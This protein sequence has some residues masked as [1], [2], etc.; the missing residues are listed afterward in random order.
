M[1]GPN[2]LLLPD[3]GPQFRRILRTAAT[4]PFVV[5]VTAGVP[6]N[7]QAALGFIGAILGPLVGG[8]VERLK[9]R[10]ASQWSI[11]LRLQDLPS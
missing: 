2:V 9:V 3:S 10:T 11:L 4:V 6:F 1:I 8:E 7:V 5:G